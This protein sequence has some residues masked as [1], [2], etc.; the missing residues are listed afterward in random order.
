MSRSS[1]R[2]QS[3]GPHKCGQFQWL[4]GM[5]CRFYNDFTAVSGIEGVSKRRAKSAAMSIKRGPTC[6]DHSGEILHRL[7]RVWLRV[8]PVSVSFLKVHCRCWFVRPSQNPQFWQG[9]IT[10]SGCLR[11]IFQFCQGLPVVSCKMGTS[12]ILGIARS[13][14]PVAQCPAQLPTPTRNCSQLGRNFGYFT[15]NRIG[16]QAQVI[17]ALLAGLSLAYLKFLA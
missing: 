3:S 9:L 5:T 2:F 15:V 8:D 1:S 7:F 11:R 16:Y 12:Q 6:Y 10:S 14:S 17:P 13:V 4:L